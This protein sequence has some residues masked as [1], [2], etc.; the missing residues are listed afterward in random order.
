MCIVGILI[1]N[2][3]FAVHGDKAAASKKRSSSPEQTAQQKVIEKAHLQATSMT[4]EVKVPPTEGS[5]ETS[6]GCKPKSQ[7][8]VGIVAMRQL[9]KD[10]APRV[11]FLTDVLTGQLLILTA[12]E[13]NNTA[14]NFLILPRAIT[15]TSFVLQF[16]LGIAFTP[17]QVISLLRDEPQR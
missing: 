4:V 8:A 15:A 17:E 2:V 11:G 6:L 10:T 9:N 13:D 12:A 14:Y 16:L 7:A 3:H 1:T 5:A